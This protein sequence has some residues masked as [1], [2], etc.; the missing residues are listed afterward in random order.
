MLLLDSVL[1]VH[2]KHF[3]T[4]TSVS[5]IHSLHQF[6]TNTKCGKQNSNIENK[7]T[8]EKVVVVVDREHER[9]F[10]KALFSKQVIVP[11]VNSCLGA[12]IYI[13]LYKHIHSDYCAN[14]NV[15]TYYVT[16]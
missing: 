7:I 2:K 8:K 13:Y 12:H 11:A 10:A 5:S 4:R 15:C 9:E 1:H 16:T 14:Q 6:I 3:N